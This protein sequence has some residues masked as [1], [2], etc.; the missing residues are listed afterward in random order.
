MLRQ[1]NHKD[2]RI[3]F[4]TQCEEPTPPRSGLLTDTLGFV[5]DDCLN[6]L[7]AILTEKG[8]ATS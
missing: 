3:L 7:T 6:H 2:W 1:Y 4:C 5:C 8:S